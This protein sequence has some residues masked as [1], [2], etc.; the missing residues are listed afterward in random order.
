MYNRFI[1]R[2]H[3]AFGSARP[4]HGRGGGFESRWVHKNM[5]KRVYI[6]HGW[7]GY[8][9]EGWFP[10]LKKELENQGFTVVIPLLPNNEEPRIKNWIPALQQIVNNPDEQTYFIGHSM[11]CQA[12]I[13]YLETLP[14][15]IKIGGAVFVAGFFKSLSNLE[16]EEIVRNVANE[17]LKTPINLQEA[18]KHLNKSIAI[19]SDNDPYV[20]LDNQDEFKNILNSK[21]IIEHEKKHFSG[22]TGTIELPIA[23]EAILE[24][25]K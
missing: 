24:M 14:K 7:D 9:K 11:G 12:I 8:P 4:W 16:D 19:F 3:S 6:I 21:I 13:R 15:N 1:Q 22:S 2:A 5:Q 18:K 25:S 10:W 23:L 17:W 20:S